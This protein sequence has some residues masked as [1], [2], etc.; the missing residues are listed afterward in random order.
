[1]Q[2][3][4]AD[5]NNGLFAARSLGKTCAIQLSN[6]D[7]NAGIPILIEIMKRYSNVINLNIFNCTV[8]EEGL[9]QIASQL[10]RFSLKTLRLSRVDM[11]YRVIQG[12]ATQI[13]ACSIIHLDISRNNLG[14]EGFKYIV[15]A[16][17]HSGLQSLKVIS[18]NI[19]SASV[20][21]LSTVL[22]GSSM[23]I[24]DLSLNRI[25]GSI[26]AL[27]DVIPKTRMEILYLNDAGL[28]TN[29]I[30]GLC[31]MIPL[32][33]T[34]ESLCLDDN[35]IDNASVF[36]LAAAISQ[37]K[38]IK[39]LS[40]SGNY[41]NDAGVINLARVLEKSLQ[42]EN[43]SLRSNRGIGELGAKA[44]LKSITNHRSMR[45]LEMLHSTNI[46]REIKIDLLSVLSCLHT[47]RAK[48]IT[49]I[50]SSRKIPRLGT[51]SMIRMLPVELFHKL[52][53]FLGGNNR[54]VFDDDDEI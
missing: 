20:I 18:T 43:L 45:T 4:I 41:L 44:L 36:K 50:C 8:S 23:R 38:S 16:I 31:N 49:V 29:D 34:L 7:I 40:L 5:Y 35:Q 17:R 13:Q 2:A 28:N 37:S 32:S 6:E 30:D 48:T 22:E 9:L 25:A 10:E 12:I 27:A 1:M 26:T 33:T 21:A 53:A 51:R 11:S 3:V 14:D 54:L 47:E 15:D 39:G 42:F 52:A 24:L 46:P 19:T